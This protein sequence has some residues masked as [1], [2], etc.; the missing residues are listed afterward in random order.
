MVSP[1]SIQDMVL[2]ALA[3]AT[4]RDPSTIAL[5][6]RFR[7]DL[8]LNSLDTIELMFKVEEAFDLMIPDSDL[9]KLV[10]VGTLIQYLQERVSSGKAAVPPTTPPNAGST[11]PPTGTVRATAQRTTNKK[12]SR[13]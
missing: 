3:D 2:K 7:D 6:H 10:T 8:G 13:A 11:K 5:S 9:P 1:A 4:K 12:R